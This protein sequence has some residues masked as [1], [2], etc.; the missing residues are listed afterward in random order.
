MINHSHIIAFIFRKKKPQSKRSEWR[1]KLADFYQCRAVLPAVERKEL[2]FESLIRIFKIRG[3][4]TLYNAAHEAYSF[5]VSY[6][7]EE[8]ML[9]KSN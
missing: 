2:I 1:E 7:E 8:R 6:P 4:P 5:A 9:G 3:R